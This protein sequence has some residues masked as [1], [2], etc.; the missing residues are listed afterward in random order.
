MSTISINRHNVSIIDRAAIRI[1]EALVA[2]GRHRAAQPRVDRG[3]ISYR[4]SYA[5]RV[6]DSSALGQQRLL[7]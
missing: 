4:D 6:R 5:E 2:W 7:P 1:G 3:T